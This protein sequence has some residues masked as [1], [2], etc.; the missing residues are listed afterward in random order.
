MSPEVMF[1]Q[2]LETQY[3]QIVFIV[4]T[5]I[6]L[7]KMALQVLRSAYERIYSILLK[8]IGAALDVIEAQLYLLIEFSTVE[9]KD[10][11]D[12]WCKIAYACKPL[13]DLLFKDGGVLAFSGI[14]KKTRNEWRGNYNLFNEF[15]CRDGLSDLISNYRALMLDELRDKIKNL[16]DKLDISPMLDRLT[17]AYLDKVEDSGIYEYMDK[18]DEWMDCAFA[19]CTS[20]ET[21][22]NF[23]EDSL[24]TM[25]LEKVGNSYVFKKALD[26]SNNVYTYQTELDLQ[27][28]KLDNLI[29]ELSSGASKQ[30]IFDRGGKGRDSLMK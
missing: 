1:C 25:A 8:G 29:D 9:I 4:D 23:Q 14:N 21:A 24:G 2:M 22:L 20:L 26:W 3:N 17:Q 12:D 7:P 30:S 15:V 28:S 13:T 27:A 11:K 10:Y 5:L 18:L 6:Q 19:V 16:K